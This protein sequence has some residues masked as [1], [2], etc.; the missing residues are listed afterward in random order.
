MPAPAGNYTRICC[1]QETD[2]NK[3]IDGLR[4]RRA[5][6]LGTGYDRGIW[7]ENNTSR[8]IEGTPKLMWYSSTGNWF[9]IATDQEM[10]R[11]APTGMQIMDT[12]NDGLFWETP[13]VYSPEA[14]MT[15]NRC[16]FFINNGKLHVLNASISGDRKF[17]GA[18]TGDYELFPYLSSQTIQSWGA[19]SGA[20][21]AYQIVYDTKAKSYKSFFNKA[22]SL[23]RFNTA[24]EDAQFNVNAMQGTPVYI[25]TINGG[26]TA[27]IMKRETGEY[28]IDVA[29]FCNVVDNGYLAQIS[30]PLSGC[31]DLDK[32]TCFESGTGGSAIF[33][34]AGNKV[35]S[36]SYT[37]GQS[38]SSLL[39]SGEA[40]DEV[41][42]MRLLS[43]GG[44][45][46]AG[47]VLWIG[48]WNESAKE[49]RVIEFEIDP[50]SGLSDSS[51]RDMSGI[52]GHPCV[53]TGVWNMFHST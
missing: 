36:Y 27:A 2:N 13:S 21:N 47:R 29:N 52:E 7:G 10:I 18:I 37:T 41:T 23:S 17:P 20:I 45:P 43:T 44:F 25:N 31:S 42:C 22:T 14:F 28:F 1:L 11:V 3:D 33:Y 30:K 8:Q 50:D 46:T 4:T 38:T 48:V 26:V 24:A 40:G 34:G 32:A 12:W 16:D 9:Y 51:C 39:W 5:L 19:V 49:G 15:V 35:Y 6:I 53:H